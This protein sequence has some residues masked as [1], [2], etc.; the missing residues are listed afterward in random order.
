MAARLI[1]RGSAWILAGSFVFAQPAP[2]GPLS[3]VR[4]SNE[5]VQA[6]LAG[7]DRID[8]AAEAELFKIIDGVTDFAAISARVTRPFCPKLSD[9]ECRELDLTFQRLLRVS[10][11]RKLGRYRADRFEYLGEE[12]KAGTALVQTLAYYRDD[13]VRLDYELELGAGRWRIV[14]YIVDDVDTIR[15]YKK[16]LTRL[17]ARNEARQVIERLQKKIAEHERQD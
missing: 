6:R 3:A 8:A 7:H 15:N 4:T 13:R 10:S 14:N 16:Q 12:V 1:F 11:I 5:Q 2:P 9:A 17:F